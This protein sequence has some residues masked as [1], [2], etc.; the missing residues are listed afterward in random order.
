[1]TP[2]YEEKCSGVVRC[3]GFAARMQHTYPQSLILWASTVSQ[4]LI[5][6]HQEIIR[7]Q[8]TETQKGAVGK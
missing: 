7:E 5:S 2:G 1:M 4:T 8:I 3:C 6:V